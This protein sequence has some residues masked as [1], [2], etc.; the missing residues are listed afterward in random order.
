MP[1]CSSDPYRVTTTCFLAVA[2]MGASVN[3][4]AQSPDDTAPAVIG[5]QPIENLIVVGTR[6]PTPATDVSS[7]VTVITAEDIER[8]GYDFAIDAIAAVPGVTVNQNGAFGGLA[9]VRIRGASSEQTLVLID[10]VPVTDPSSPGGGFNFASLDTAD[11]A[12]IEVL[13]GPQSVLWGSDAIGG[14]VNIITHRG[15]LAPPLSGFLEGG[16]FGTLR[17][18][19]AGAG[20]FDRGEFRVAVS[21]IRTDGI[22]KADEADGNEE[23][24]GFESLTVNAT[25]AIELPANG[26]LEATIRYVTAENDF[27]SFGSQTGVVDGDEVGDSR[28]LSATLT[29]RF[30]GLWNDHLDLMGMFG[31]ADIERENFT[32][33]ISSFTADGQ[34]TVFRG[35]ATL[36]PAQAHRIALGAEHEGTETDEDTSIASVFALWEY[37]PID[38]VAVSAGIRRDDHERF[39]AETTGRASLAVTPLDGLTLRSAWGQGFKAPTLFQTTFFCCGASEPNSDLQP[40]SSNSWEVGF[41]WRVNSRASLSA[42]WFEQDFENLIVFDFGIGGYDNVPGATNRGLEVA[43]AIQLTPILGLGLTYAYIEARDNT[44]ARLVRVPQNSG[45]VELSLTPRGPFSASLVARY[46][47]E[48]ADSRGAVERWL[49]LDVSA[50]YAIGERYELFARLE[51]AADAQYQQIFG[52]GTPGI[53]GTIGFRGH[54]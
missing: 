33:G 1:I 6:L 19:V 34:R 41:D 20:S 52:Y 28:Q 38:A 24:D 37:S 25:G 18:G 21:G 51:N 22:S 10:G 5:A 43:G 40:E 39:G 26:R 54:L 3:V 8:R 46:N 35:Q 31:Y 36:R 53:S 14:V 45:D 12:R 50:S 44:G 32:D 11:I 17:S 42:T 47:G 15:A 30:E 29:A 13:R 16:S 2:A 49:R 27:D 9:S 7:S 4:L 23:S 48:E